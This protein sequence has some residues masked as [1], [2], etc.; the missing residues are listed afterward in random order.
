M[1]KLI[2]LSV[3]FLLTVVILSWLSTATKASLQSVTIQSNIAFASGGD[4]ENNGQ[5]DAGDTITFSYAIT[6]TTKRTFSRNTLKTNVPRDRLNF[7]HDVRGV[8]SISDRNGI[9]EIPNLRLDAHQELVVSFSARINYFSGADLAIWTQPELVAH[10]GA[11]LGGA[12]RK[13]MNV[14]SWKNEVFPS[15]VKNKRR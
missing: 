4:L 9:L 10:D 14:R 12:I 2:V 15:S 6:N 7:I 5:F 11:S 13:E 1:K 3:S 8:A